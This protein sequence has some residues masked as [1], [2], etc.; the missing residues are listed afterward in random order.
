MPARASFPPQLA[1]HAPVPEPPGI[2]SDWMR[3]VDIE[4]TPSPSCPPPPHLLVLGDVG[5][6]VEAEYLGVGGDGQALDVLHVV[7]V[8]A[9]GGGE[10]QP[11][12]GIPAQERG[13]RSRGEVV[14]R[15]T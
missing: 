9:L 2:P 10:V 1:Q 7:V 6:G 11:G 14:R 4:P 3:D 15:A 8:G 5:V 13:R 12:G